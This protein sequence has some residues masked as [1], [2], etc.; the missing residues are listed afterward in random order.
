M[1]WR[2]RSPQHPSSPGTALLTCAPVTLSFSVPAE[3]RLWERRS[4]HTAAP[5]VLST[6]TASVL[7]EQFLLGH[8]R[9]WPGAFCW[10][11]S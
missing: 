10:T 8:V 9:G 4:G 7:N 3:H 1:S 2:C 5:P 11:L 6:H